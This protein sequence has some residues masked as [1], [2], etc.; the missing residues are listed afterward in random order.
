MDI[1]IH[2]EDEQVQKLE[3]IQQQTNQDA[4]TLLN[5]TLIEAINTYY[6]Q[7]QV[8]NPDPLAQLRQSKFIGCF[9]GDPDLAANSKANFQAIMNEKY[10]PR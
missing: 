1:T 8:S 7:I 9:N 5:R 10:D 3:Y 4:A 6:Q 2:L